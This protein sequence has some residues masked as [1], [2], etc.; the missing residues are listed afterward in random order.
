[1]ITPIGPRRTP[2]STAR[3]VEPKSA[4]SD[5]GS[6][7]GREPDRASVPALVPLQ[8]SEDSRTGTFRSGAHTHAPFVTHLI[9]TYHNLPQ[10]R[11]RRRAD[12][13]HTLDRYRET[14]A[15]NGYLPGGM[16]IQRSV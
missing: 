12:P 15:M 7:T 9:A 11:T 10:T 13:G 8:R 6:A 5:S 14:D 2:H 1:M 16:I 4:T 3:R